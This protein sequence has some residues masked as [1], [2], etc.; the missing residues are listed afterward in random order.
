MKK[1]IA[2]VRVQI[3]LRTDV[4]SWIAIGIRTQTHWDS[5]PLIDPLDHGSLETPI[6][7]FA[8]KLLTNHNKFNSLNFLV[9][10]PLE[11]IY[12]TQFKN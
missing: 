4:I 7:Y 1:R 6:E 5:V 2:E 10:K 3:Y 11:I 8:K 12:H 9:I